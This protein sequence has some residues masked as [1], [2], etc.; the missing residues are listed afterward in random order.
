VMHATNLRPHLMMRPGEGLWQF[1][2]DSHLS[3]FLHARGIAH[4]VTTDE[5][6][7]REARPRS[8]LHG[9]PPP[10]PVCFI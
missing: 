10:S 4:D 5:H 9:L 1:P 2:A 8:H 6:L 3:S 7:H